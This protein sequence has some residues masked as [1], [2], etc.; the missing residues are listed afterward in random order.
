MNVYF[1]SDKW[2]EKDGWMEFFFLSRQHHHHYLKVNNKSHSAFKT[3]EQMEMDN[4][5][6]TEPY[7]LWCG[8]SEV[9]E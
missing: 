4:H 8:V 9:T 7:L 2:K 3:G 6:Q 1:F 5:S